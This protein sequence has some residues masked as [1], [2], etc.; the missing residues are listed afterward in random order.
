[1]TQPSI[2]DGNLNRRGVRIEGHSVPTITLQGLTIQN[3]HGKIEGGGGILIKN[4]PVIVQNCHIVSGTTTIGSG[5]GG[6]IQVDFGEVVLVDNLIRNSNATKGGGVSVGNTSITRIG[7]TLL[8]NVAFFGGGLQVGNSGRVT[9]YGNRIIGSQTGAGQ[10]PG[11][12]IWEAGT[13]DGRNDVVAQNFSGLGDGE[14]IKVESGGSLIA[15]H[16]T[17]AGND[18]YGVIVN[19]GSAVLTN[20]IVA[21]VTIDID[22][23]FRPV[24][25]GFDIGADELAYWSYI[26]IVIKS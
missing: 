21:G 20:T 7:N 12:L 11:I 5:A 1:V 25:L 14:G 23:D 9:M 16:W 2:I 24:L 10:G 18:G 3:G 13:V 4:G 6:G 17:V 8:D 22:G 15:R 19:G 26:P